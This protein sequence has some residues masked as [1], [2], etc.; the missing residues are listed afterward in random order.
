MHA[1][2]IDSYAHLF[3]CLE[4]NLAAGS[5]GCATFQGHATTCKVQAQL[6]GQPDEA[7]HLAPPLWSQASQEEMSTPAKTWRGPHL[8]FEPLFGT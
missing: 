8:L 5:P 7:C 4:A 2:Y 6:Q 1:E 3:R